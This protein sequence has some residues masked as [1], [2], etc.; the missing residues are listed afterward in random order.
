MNFET[1][2]FRDKKLLDFI[3]ETTIALVEFERVPWGK[4]SGIFN[5]SVNCAEIK[6]SS[7]LLRISSVG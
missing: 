6:S 2:R 3:A 1:V 7:R 5:K 4:N